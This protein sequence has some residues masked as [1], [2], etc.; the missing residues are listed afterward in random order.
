MNYDD[1]IN[2]P[3]HVSKK[4]AQMSLEERSAQFAPFSPLTGYEEMVEE[5]GRIT[6]KKIEITEELKEELNR[7]LQEIKE[8]IEEKPKTI[9]MYF[10]EDLNKERRQIYY[11]YW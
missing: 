11:Y 4:H 7:K 3:H 9:I 5:T 6:S 2:M 1:I 10:V 8:N